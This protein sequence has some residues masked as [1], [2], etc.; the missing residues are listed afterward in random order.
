M[1]DITW[2]TNMNYQKIESCS[3]ANGTGWRVVLWVS[4][5]E[6]HCPGCHNAD[7]WDDKAGRE[8]TQQQFELIEKL[9]KDDFIQ[10]LTLSG[11]DPLY[12]KN[13]ETVTALAK[14]VKEEYPHKD[15]WLYT[16]YCYE[17]IKHLEIINYVDVIVDGEYLQQQRDI[18][19]PFRG[20]TNQRIIDV[21]ASVK[22][23]KVV[24]KA[25]FE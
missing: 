17:M 16:G 11:G 25:D 20:S 5:C 12:P 4:G 21:E 24:L 1:S 13:I 22:E 23:N 15:I 10:G 9:L 6:H 2:C 19:L 18:S 3:L 8:F 7:L 14:T